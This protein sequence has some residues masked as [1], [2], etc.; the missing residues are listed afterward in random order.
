MIPYKRLKKMRISGFDDVLV[1]GLKP[2]QTCVGG[3]PNFIRLLL[4]VEGYR[5][6]GAYIAIKKYWPFQIMIFQ[7]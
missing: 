6:R 4:S 5:S 1:V 2:V 3:I 7:Y